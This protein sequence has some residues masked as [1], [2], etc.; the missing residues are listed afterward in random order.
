MFLTALIAASFCFGFFIES[1]VG[2]GGGLIAYSILGFFVDIKTMILAG[3]YIG[4]LSSL[5]IAATDFKSFN[6]EIL[7]K[8]LPFCL[9][10]TIIGSFIFSVVNAEILSVFLGVLL[11]LLAIKLVFFEH[12]KIAKILQ[13]KLLLIGGISHGAFGIGGPFFVNALKS[14]FKNKSELRTTMAI[15]FVFFNIIR[16]LYLSLSGTLK[17]NFF[18]NI[19]WVVF[20]IFIAIKLGHKIHIKIDE[21]FFK[22]MIAIITAIG[23][24]KL[25]FS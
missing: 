9:S 5:Y 17:L 7:I 13:K 12:L 24:I 19:W 8:S 11:I 22:K 2:F 18:Y 15:F 21:D 6:K 14:S 23:G 10:G 16:I 20:P 25:L 3:L 1:I 4:T